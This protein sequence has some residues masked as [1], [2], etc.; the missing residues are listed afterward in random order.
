M[1]DYSRTEIS[2]LFTALE[3]QMDRLKHYPGEFPSDEAEALRYLF[4]DFEL[5]AK[6]RGLIY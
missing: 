4:K 1:D 3:E 5:E 6:Y 2:V